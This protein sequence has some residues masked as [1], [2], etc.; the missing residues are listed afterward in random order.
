M[1]Q[2]G[3]G[4]LVGLGLGWQAGLQ[5]LPLFWQAPG[6]LSSRWA[7]WRTGVFWGRGLS[8]LLTAPGGPG[9]MGLAQMPS[10]RDSA[11]SSK[12]GHHT[13]S[14]DE[15]ATSKFWRRFCGLSCP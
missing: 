13:Y 14:A 6:T 10:P 12:T 7:G 1:G 3:Q 2:K 5:L 11:D 8:C 4:H 15:K 9:A